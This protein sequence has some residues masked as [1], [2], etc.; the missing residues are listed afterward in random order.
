M[1][2]ELNQDPKRFFQGDIL[3]NFPVTILPDI[4]KIVRLQDK[5]KNFSVAHVY[6]KDKL[7]DAFVNGSEPVLAKASLMNIMILSQTCDI[8]HRDFISIAPIFPI[9]NIENKSK[10]EVIRKKR[11]LYRFH[12][13]AEGKFEESF[14]D[15]TTINSVRRTTLKLEHRTLSLSHFGRSHLIYFIYNYFNRPFLPD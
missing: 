4:I 13:P 9:T 1:F 15:I 7:K 5:L 12:L 10:R 6:E 3:K 11:V 2:Y 14:L 8:E